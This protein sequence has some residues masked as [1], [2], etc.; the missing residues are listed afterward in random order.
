MGLIKKLVSKHA[1]ALIKRMARDLED[2]KE[3]CRRLVD[4]CGTAEREVIRVRRELETTLRE[5]AAL[6][7]EQ[8]CD[9]QNPLGYVCW[10]CGA[11]PKPQYPD[12]G[13]GQ[14]T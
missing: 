12:Q 14:P 10:S 5:Y 13:K 3:L 2:E 6:K 9:P 1:D 4:A 8:H 11:M 7:Q